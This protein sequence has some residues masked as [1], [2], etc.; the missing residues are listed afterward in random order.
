MIAAMANHPVVPSVSLE[1]R[2]TS[3]PDFPTQ[4]NNLSI[5][6]IYVDLLRNDQHFRSSTL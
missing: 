4:E 5:G 2:A 6:R 3:R 1:T